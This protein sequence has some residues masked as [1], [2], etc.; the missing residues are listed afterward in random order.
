MFSH[1]TTARGIT[2][3]L[4]LGLAAGAAA[5]H[6][7]GTGN[8]KNKKQARRIVFPVIGQVQYT[9]DF[10]DARSQGPH[11]GNDIM[12]PRKAFAVAA[13]GGVVKFW[14]HSSAAGCMLYLYGRSGT[15]YLYIHLNNDRTMRNDNRGKCAPGGSYAPK[16]RSGQ[17]V[18]AGQLI[19][20][21]GDSGDANGIHPHLHFEVHPHDGR[22][23]NPYPHLNRARRLLFTTLA[24]SNIRVALGGRVVSKTVASLTLQV[25]CI[26]AR[27]GRLRVHGLR[28]KVTIEVPPTAEILR[29]TAERGSAAYETTLDA[30]TKGQRVDI[31]T[32]RMERT[33]GA[34]IGKTGSLSANRVLLTDRR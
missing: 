16:L 10:G 11:E 3:L 28:R 20:Y 29:R 5:A 8:H 17:K 2:L 22:A 9:N 18:R 31:A 30:A 24:G 26:L 33:L 1:R 27:P 34:L 13:E 6:P 12:A 14:T 23:V 15:T 25:R 32:P 21:V 19:G 7:P 4:L